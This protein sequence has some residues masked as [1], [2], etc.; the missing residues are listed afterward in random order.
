MTIMRSER[1]GFFFLRDF[2][3]HARVPICDREDP[4]NN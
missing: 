4:D 1:P 2:E 3:D